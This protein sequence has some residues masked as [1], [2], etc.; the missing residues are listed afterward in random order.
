MGNKG[1]KMSNA[2]HSGVKWITYC[3]PT[4]EFAKYLN[5]NNLSWNQRMDTMKAGDTQKK[6]EI[7]Q[8]YSILHK[9]L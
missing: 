2:L 6:I 3:R 5:M 8:F 7:S 1:E 4:A 9:P